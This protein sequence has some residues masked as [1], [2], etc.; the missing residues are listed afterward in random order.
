M[1]TLKLTPSYLNN[2]EMAHNIL[3]KNRWFTQESWE[4][5]ANKGEL[6]MY[7]NMLSQTDK[8]KDI[9]DFYKK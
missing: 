7:V 3:S 4:D 8:I 1:A 9:D 6:D 5:F 2:Y